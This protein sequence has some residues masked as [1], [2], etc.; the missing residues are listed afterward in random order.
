MAKADVKTQRAGA[1][2]GFKNIQELDRAQNIV[3][4]R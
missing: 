3:E 2:G 1:M 4:I